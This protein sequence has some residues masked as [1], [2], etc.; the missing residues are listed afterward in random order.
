MNELNNNNKL[1]IKCVKGQI[2]DIDLYPNKQGNNGLA[3]QPYPYR[4]LNYI[5]TD[6]IG[7]KR[8]LTALIYN[9]VYIKVNGKS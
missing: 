7:N 9:E 2:R 4:L 8:Y 6:G 3:I 5:I 1:N